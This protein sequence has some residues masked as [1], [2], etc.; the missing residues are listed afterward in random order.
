[1]KILGGNPWDWPNI[2]EGFSFG[3]RASKHT[4]TKF[5]PFFV[6]Y[7]QEPTLPIDVKYNLVYIERNES[8]RPFNKE[9]FDAVLT[10]AISIRANI[11]QTAAE[12]ICSAQENQHRDYIRHHQVPNKIKVGQKVYLKNQRRMDKKGSKFSRKWF[13]PV[14]VYSISNKN[15]PLFLNKQRWNT[16]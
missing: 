9:T 8:E 5:S 16:N 14:T 12:N 10:T 2:I 13:G 3:H 1:M 7:D 15:L 6:I 4:S 11:H